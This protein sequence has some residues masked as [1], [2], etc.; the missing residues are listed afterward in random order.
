MNNWNEA[1]ASD[2]YKDLPWILRLGLFDVVRGIA[3]EDENK[4]DSKEL[5]ATEVTKE[6]AKDELI[7]LMD[8]YKCLEETPGQIAEKLIKK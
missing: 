1:R 8:E 7:Y 5:E 4:E 2:S 3:T 6:F